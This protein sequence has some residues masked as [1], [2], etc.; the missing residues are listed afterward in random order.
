[1][2]KKMV[3]V[4]GLGQM[5]KL[6][7]E[8]LI[9]SGVAPDRII[10]IDIDPEKVLVAREKFP[11]VSFYKTCDDVI[12]P[13]TDDLQIWNH[14]F[15]DTA[16]VATNTPSHHRVIIDLME[17]GV[18]NILCEKPL[19][20][21]MS[22]VDEIADA[23]VRCEAQIYTAFLMSFS[24]AILHVIKR[25]QDEGL[26]MTEGSV[27]WGKNR[28]GDSRPTPGDLED[29]TVHGVG[30]LH[31][32]CSI[33]QVIRYVFVAAQLTYPNYANVEAQAKAHTLDESFP[34]TVNASTMAIERISTDRGEV[35][36]NLH[37][38]FLLGSQTRRVTALLSRADDP[39]QPV[40]AVEFNFDVK[41]DGK[42]IDQLAITTLDGNNVELL[43]FDCNKL[44]DQTEAFMAAASGNKI[45]P[46]LTGF[47]EARNAVGFTEAVLQSHKAAGCMVT[48]YTAES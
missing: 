37:S 40:V 33:N 41:I 14:G 36:C 38:S 15:I 31:A 28:F 10:G 8:K 44:L 13:Y 5:G 23:M 39:H 43:E 2:N 30:I 11:D 45:D 26:I 27:L 24:P 46:R 6:Y 3:M 32:L 47:E 20:L 1:M 34:V 9:Q 12:H 42:I 35:L 4:V 29:E 18:R 17:R 7:V 48:A 22:A 25:M 21:N 16:I 19:G